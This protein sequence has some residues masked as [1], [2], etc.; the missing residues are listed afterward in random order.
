MTCSHIKIELKSSLS[1]IFVVL[2]HQNCINVCVCQKTHRKKNPTSTYNT[3]L[4]WNRKNNH[5]T[6]HRANLL[7]QGTGQQHQIVLCMSNELHL[8]AGTHFYKR[9]QQ[10]L[11]ASFHKTCIWIFFSKA[12]FQN[13]FREKHYAIDLKPLS[14]ASDPPTT[15]TTIS[16][17]SH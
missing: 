2:R 11:G 8:Y 12:F 1:K 10:T 14:Q 6:E 16:R 17:A 7:N 9:S 15:N 5:E 4:F 3:D 13:P